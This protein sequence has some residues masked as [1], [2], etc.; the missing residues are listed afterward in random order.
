MAKY[1][2]SLT[3]DYVPQWTSIEA[4]RELLQNAKDQEQADPE[5]KK[6][7]EYDKENETLRI[8]NK[9]TQL[10]IETLLLGSGSKKEKK[11]QLG[12]YGEGYKLAILVLLREGK[13]FT[14]YNDAVRELWHTTLQKKKR[15]NGVRVPTV[16]VK[17]GVRHGGTTDSLV[18][19]VKGLTVAEYEEIQANTLWLQELE[20]GVDKVED[21]FT[22]SSVLLGDTQKGRIYVGGLY[23]STEEEVQKGY[24]FAPGTLTLNRDRS[25]LRM[26]DISYYASR[27]WSNLMQEQRQELYATYKELVRLG[28]SEL[29]DLGKYVSF[30]YETEG[31]EVSPSKE[32]KEEFQEE[33]GDKAY[34]TCTEGD[35]EEI[36]KLGGQPVIVSAVHTRLL[37]QELPELKAEAREL[38]GKEQLW[39]FYTA[40]SSTWTQSEKIEFEKI[41]ELI[42]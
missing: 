26:T 13:S 12:E 8:S 4:V 3:E 20:E 18:I 38:T 33:Y 11:D 30:P 9:S 40:H 5:A 16:T 34:P 42:N 2:I 21:P 36:R 25:M 23:V 41:Y 37:R 31:S 39:L 17:K 22:G 35:A 15:Y 28:A 24:D 7:I 19:E 27:L 32:L 6:T 10:K 29:G 14:V 1:E